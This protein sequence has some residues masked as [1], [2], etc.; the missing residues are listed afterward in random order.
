[1]CASG[2]DL[3]LSLR[4]ATGIPGPLFQIPTAGTPRSFTN[5]RFLLLHLERSDV[6]R[7]PMVGQ[8]IYEL[9]VGAFTMEGTFDAAIE[10]LDFLKRFGITLL[11]LMPIAECSGRWN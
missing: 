9:H 2:D 3:S 8:V 1:M 4:W 7:G 11:E 5:C 6:A 10:Q